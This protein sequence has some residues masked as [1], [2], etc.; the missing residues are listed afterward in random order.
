MKDIIS[1]IDAAI[2]A[3]LG[4]VGH[5]HGLCR[6]IVGDDKAGTYPI[7][8]DKNAYKVAPDDKYELAIYHRLIDSGI[9]LDED[10]SFG[11][12]NSKKNNQKIRTIVIIDQKSNI[13]IS[14]VYNAIPDKLFID[15]YKSIYVDSEVSLDVNQEQVWVAEWAE[16]YKD[17]RQMRYFV[18]ALEYT[19]EF[20]KCST[21]CT[22]PSTTPV[23]DTSNALL[24]DDGNCVQYSN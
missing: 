20:I 7:K 1:Q 3:G 10:T 12:K 4:N 18:Y 19:C 9:V 8:V 13:E 23:V 5:F 22:V 2:F 16:A 21:L 17:K 14:D 11:R 6:L 15:G 24:Y